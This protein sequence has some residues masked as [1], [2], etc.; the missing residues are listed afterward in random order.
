MEHG[1]GDDDTGDNNDTGDGN[2]NGTIRIQN[3]AH[4]ERLR[5]LAAENPE[6]CDPTF[7]KETMDRYEKSR[8]AFSG[9]SKEDYTKSNDVGKL[10]LPAFFSGK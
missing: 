6:W 2:G 10:K 4:A 7:G 8:N 3:V 5:L 1:H 9:K